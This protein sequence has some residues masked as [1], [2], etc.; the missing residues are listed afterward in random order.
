[1]KISWQIPVAVIEFLGE[2]IRIRKRSLHA[3][4]A[5]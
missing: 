4:M 1:M 5:S 3:I 2:R